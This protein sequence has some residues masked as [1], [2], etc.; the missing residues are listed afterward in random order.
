MYIDKVVD[1]YILKMSK[2]QNFEEGDILETYVSLIEDL[3]SDKI[4]TMITVYNENRQLYGRYKF[5]D[6]LNENKYI[7]HFNKILGKEVYQINSKTYK[8]ERIS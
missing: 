6:D 8:I 5:R 7:N 1:I 2:C 4:E 3:R